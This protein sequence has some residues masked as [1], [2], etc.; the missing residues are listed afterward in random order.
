[1]N[2][3]NRGYF[4]F[5]WCMFHSG[6]VN[7]EGDSGN[8][9]V[10]IQ[11]PPHCLHRHNEQMCMIHALVHVCVLL[12]SPMCKGFSFYSVNPIAPLY[13]YFQVTMVMQV[14]CM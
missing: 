5:F 2:G 10:K 9:K 4:P 7:P 11:Q 6:L 1:M 3:L 13:S 12:N 8:T 14:T